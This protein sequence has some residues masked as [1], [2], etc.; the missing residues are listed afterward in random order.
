MNL[1]AF[2]DELPR[3]GASIFAR[4]IGVSTVYL[5]QLAARQGGRKPSPELCVVI[6]R[7]SNRQ[8]TRPERR[9]DWRLIW[10]ELSPE[11][12]ETGSA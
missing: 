6:E 5:S 8:V 12:E 11:G 3:G 10:P 4:R 1:R 7:Q 9:D 2:L